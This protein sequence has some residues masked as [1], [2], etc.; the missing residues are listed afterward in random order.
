MSKTG[1]YICFLLPVLF[2]LELTSTTIAPDVT[3]EETM[4]LYQGLCC[5]SLIKVIASST[6]FLCVRQSIDQGYLV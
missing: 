2:V 3:V 6:H 5:Y 4:L 1:P